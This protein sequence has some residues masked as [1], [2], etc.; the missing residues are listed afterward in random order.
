VNLF[1]WIASS[2]F[3]HLVLAEILFS[4]PGF[5]ESMSRSDFEGPLT[6]EWVLWSAFVWC[7]LGALG[8]VVFWYA[9]TSPL[10]NRRKGGR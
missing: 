9:V 6:I 8:A 1:K 7:S 4:V 5:L 2:L 10:I 3:G